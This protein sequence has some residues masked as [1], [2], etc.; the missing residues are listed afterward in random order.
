MT[1]IDHH[2]VI[3]RHGPGPALEN[4]PDSRQ[5]HSSRRL[6][7]VTYL[8]PLWSLDNSYAREPEAFFP[9]AIMAAYTITQDNQW[10]YDAHREPIANGNPVD[11]LIRYC[12]AYYAIRFDLQ[13]FRHRYTPLIPTTTYRSMTMTL[14]Y[15]TDHLPLNRWRWRMT[16]IPTPILSLGPEPKHPFRSKLKTPFHP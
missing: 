9:Q 6:D 13:D 5:F 1:H 7:D 8:I 16:I 4:I 3:N 10:T 15:S 2:K 14:P 11:A 12:D